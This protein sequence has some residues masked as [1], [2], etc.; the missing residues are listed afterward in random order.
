MNVQDFKREFR[1]TAEGLGIVLL[2]LAGLTSGIGIIFAAG[3]LPLLIT[4]WLAIVS[5]PCA[6][7]LFLCFVSLM[8]LVMDTDS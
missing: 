2:L 5:V 4:P 7:L 6:L 8:G 3:Y 1:H